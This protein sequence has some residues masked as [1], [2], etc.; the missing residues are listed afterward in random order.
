MKKLISLL[1]A[2]LLLC[3]V[4]PAATAETEPGTWAIYIYMC[5]SDLESDASHATDNLNELLAQPLPANVTF[6]IQTGGSTAWHRADVDPDHLCRF[7]IY[8]HGEGNRF[9]LVE[10][11]PQ[12]SMSEPATFES[13]A[14]F[15]HENYPA[16]HTMLI[17]WDHG[18]GTIY[19]ACIDRNYGNTGLPVSAMAQACH[20]VFGTDPNDP[21]LDIIAF[22]C[23][24]MATIDVANAFSG[25]ARYLLASEE[26][27]PAAGWDYTALAAAFI[28]DP[29]IDPRTLGITI[30]ND[31][32]AYYV[33][34]GKASTVTLSMIDLNK[35]DPLVIACENLGL[36]LYASMYETP[37]QY[38][39]FALI[40][41]KAENYG[42][43]SR[44]QGY[45]NLVDLYDFAAAYLDQGLEEAYAVCDAINNCVVCSVAGPFRKNSHGISFYFPYNGKTDEL[46]VLDKE[47]AVVSFGALY[48]MATGKP[49]SPAQRDLILEHTSLDPDKSPVIPSFI[50]VDTSHTG[51]QLNENRRVYASFGP[52]VGSTVVQVVA[53]LFY[54]SPNGAFYYLGTDDEIIAD[55]DNAVFTDDFKCKWVYIYDWVAF[56]SLDY[57]GKDYHI[58]SIP[59]EYNGKR[60]FM[61]RGFNFTEGV[62]EN[63][64]VRAMNADPGASRSFFLDEGEPFRL[65]Q[66]VMDNETGDFIYIA[67]ADLEY[68]SDMFSYRSLPNGRYTM[69]FRL[70]DTFRNTIF[71]DSWK[72]RLE[73]GMIYYE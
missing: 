22:D 26:I 54:T 47:G 43:N 39:D 48:S 68:H 15:A 13:F 63:L 11:L 3:A 40:T 1:L 36:V 34:K 64:G 25:C 23:C 2:V 37:S 9:D 72:F 46:E 70:E 57:D 4:L 28:K 30:C 53:N 45:H 18:G 61:Q 5:G 62:W 58:Y 50:N 52:G 55:F 65:L 32:M 69:E 6:V 49:Y 29:G 27:I 7:V 35:I 31:Y 59:I 67:V 8:N 19:G 12:A 51:L 56:M 38:Q 42:G 71:S 17:V 44:V 41:L 24:L 20:N 66:M 60:Y 73:D 21:P 16:D 14:S 33:S 10:K